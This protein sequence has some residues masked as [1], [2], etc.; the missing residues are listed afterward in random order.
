[1]LTAKP[2]INLNSEKHPPVI[3]KFNTLYKNISIQTN[4]N[5]FQRE[6]F[7]VLFCFTSYRKVE[8]RS[9]TVG[10]NV[11]YQFINAL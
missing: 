11:C 7:Q 5:A 9:I 10:I 6:L 8:C 4:C 1:M 3:Y 2:N